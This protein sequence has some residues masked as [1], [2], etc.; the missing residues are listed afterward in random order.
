MVMQTFYPRGKGLLIMCE[1]LSGEGAMS[2]EKAGFELAF[3][4]EQSPYFFRA[5]KQSRAR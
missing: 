5:Y 1:A 2:F 4:I 3:S